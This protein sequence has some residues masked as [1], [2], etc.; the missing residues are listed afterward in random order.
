MAA[1]MSALDIEQTE[2]PRLEINND[3]EVDMNTD[4]L[5][6]KQSESLPAALANIN[7]CVLDDVVLKKLVDPEIYLAFDECR[8]SGTPMS[9]AA[10][11]ALAYTPEIRHDEP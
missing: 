9:K 10:A 11:N 1:P 2:I 6:G 3:K 5:H 7:S 8:A 4:Y